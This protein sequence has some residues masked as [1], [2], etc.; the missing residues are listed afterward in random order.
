LQEQTTPIMD[1]I[2]AS[3][4]PYRRALLQRLQLPFRCV[5]P[6]VDE[7][8]LPGEAPATMAGRLALAKA[9]SVA[10]LHPEALVIGSDQVAALD[11]RVLGKPGSHQAARDQLQ[12]CSGRELDFY[13]G[14]ALACAA[15]GLQQVHVEPFRVV[16]RSLDSARIETYL[17]REQPYDCAGSFKWEGLGIALFTRLQGDDP[18]SLEGLP[19][20]SLVR[21]LGAAGV[22]VLADQG[23][24]GDRSGPGSA[25]ARTSAAINSTEAPSAS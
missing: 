19:L 3:T 7:S 9:Q 11:D 16:F 10:L 12:A 17:Q 15:R 24:S 6:P 2:L 18:T 1:I 4:S 22:D 5:A 13:T 25:A 8:R 14:V 21:L 20:V 23:C